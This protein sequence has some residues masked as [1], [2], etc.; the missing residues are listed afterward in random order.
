MCCLRRGPHRRLQRECLDLLRLTFKCQR[1][2]E[3]QM[4]QGWQHSLAQLRGMDLVYQGLARVAASPA[5]RLLFQ[6][7]C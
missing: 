5:S 3:K 1:L 6:K 2:N 4:V 7:A